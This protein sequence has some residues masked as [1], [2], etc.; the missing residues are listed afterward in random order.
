VRDERSWIAL[1]GVGFRYD[2]DVALAGVDLA[3]GAGDR[4]VV[5]GPNG[6]GKTTLLRLLLGLAE[7]SSGR[8]ERRP[9]D[10]PLRLGYVPQFPAFD[11]NFPLRVEDVILDG[12]LR[13]RR[14]ARSAAPERRAAFAELV[15]RLELGGLLGA[16]LTEL[17]GGELKRTL[18]ARALI[19]RPQL[20]VLDEPTASLDAAS[21]AALWSLVAALPAATCVVLA[22][23]DLAPDTFRPTRA[24]RV[25]RGVS[26]L[27]LATLHEPALLCG[28]GHD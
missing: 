1:D 15:A 3:L 2:G 26:E 23:H 18:I 13:D 5:L 20:L 9:P 28:H 27:D 25:D 7:P 22:T 16:Y 11:R 4:L 12:C 17:S 21:R 24:L 10:G 14:G 8:I 19:G 6:G